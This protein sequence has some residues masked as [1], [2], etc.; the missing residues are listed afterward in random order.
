MWD[1]EKD[2][3]SFSCRPTRRSFGS[4]QKRGFWLVAAGVE[5]S[6]AK[7]EF[8]TTWF[9]R[10]LAGGCRS[11]WAATVARATYRAAVP[12]RF[13]LTSFLSDSYRGNGQLVFVDIM[14]FVSGPQ[15][16]PQWWV[17]R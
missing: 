17:R 13:V 15:L 14:L 5:V 4:R 7:A 6:G 3:H 9:G 1:V 10:N 16:T 11:D 12:I 2:P 8:A